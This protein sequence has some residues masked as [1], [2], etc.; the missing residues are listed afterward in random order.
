MARYI[1][2]LPEGEARWEAATPEQKA[3]GYETHGKFAALLA[4]RGHQITGGAELQ[5]SRTTTTIHRTGDGFTVTEGPYAEATEHLTG[6]YSI[7]TDDLDDLVECCKV[8]AELEQ[9]IELR[10]VATRGE[11]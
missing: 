3:A 1:L 5:H 6:F 9:T 4:E 10:P 7:E 11:A 2:L 8:L